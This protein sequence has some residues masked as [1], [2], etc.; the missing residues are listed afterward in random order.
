[1]KKITF[2]F[3]LS[4]FSFLPLS[5]QLIVATPETDLLLERQTMKM[6]ELA[7][8]QQLKDYEYYAE[9][10]A[11]FAEV[12]ASVKNTASTIK[13]ISKIS[14]KLK[15]QTAAGW[16]QEIDKHIAATIPE[17]SELKD[18]VIETVKDKAGFVKG[19]YSEYVSKWSKEAKEYHEHFFEN[20]ENH[21]MF[22][23]LFPAVAKM[24]K[25]LKKGESARKI[26]HKA[27]LESGLEYEM[28][29]DIYRKN[30]FKAYYDE[31]M[32]QAKLN[33]NIEAIGL[34]NLMQSNYV[35]V[36]LLEN[37][38]KNSD[39]AIMKEQ[40]EKDSSSAYLKLRKK[41]DEANKKKE[42]VLEIFGLKKKK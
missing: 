28:K 29:N 17:Y 8:R 2:V 12:I 18:E 4:M 38:K 19:K 31:Y 40:F 36:E 10:I 14:D 5:A 7:M 21:T 41:I 35:T 39:I 32:Q 30:T 23:E 34:A 15:S 37:I 9:Y 25:N 27:W 33:D 1:M 13:N 42:G 3:L 11:Q 26:I 22:P 24:G 16:L 20:Y 6:A